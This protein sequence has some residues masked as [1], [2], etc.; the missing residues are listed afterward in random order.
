MMIGS[1]IQVMLRLLPQQFQIGITDERD[2]WSRP[3][4]W[5]SGGMMYLPSLMKFGTGVQKL[6]GGEIHRQTAR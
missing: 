1:G 5:P 3:L 2:L 4:R 6:L